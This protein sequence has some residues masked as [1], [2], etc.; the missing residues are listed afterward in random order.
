M[1]RKQGK[2]DK[3]RESKSELRGKGGD[4]TK[5]RG[6]DGH[7]IGWISE[8]SECSSCLAHPGETKAGATASESRV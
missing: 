5:W 4:G 2:E 1:I 8:K 6:M 7:G 3:R